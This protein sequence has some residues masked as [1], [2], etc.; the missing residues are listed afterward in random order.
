MSDAPEPKEFEDTIDDHPNPT[1]CSKPMQ[2]VGRARSAWWCSSCGT[3]EQ[4]SPAKPGPRSTYPRSRTACELRYWM[5]T[6]MEGV[7]GADALKAVMHLVQVRGGPEHDDIK[8]RDDGLH[9]P[10]ARYEKTELRLVRAL[11]DGEDDSELLDRLFSILIAMEPGDRRAC[12]RA[13]V[14]NGMSEVRCPSP[15][16]SDES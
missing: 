6:L 13:L 8:I 5:S 1:C 10:V 14:R 9:A 16:E 4:W 11:A 15:S 12:L 7:K 2:L 3:I